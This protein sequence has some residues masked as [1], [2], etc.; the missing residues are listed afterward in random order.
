[1]HVSGTQKLFDV[2]EKTLSMFLKLSQGIAY[3]NSGQYANYEVQ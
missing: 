2:H 1:M 3:A